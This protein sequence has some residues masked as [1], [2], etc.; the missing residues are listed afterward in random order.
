MYHTKKSRKVLNIEKT[1][2][3]HKQRQG[4]LWHSSTALEHQVPS[5]DISFWFLLRKSAFVEDFFGH[6]VKTKKFGAITPTP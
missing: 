5:P 1:I 2:P 3:R 6:F 4:R